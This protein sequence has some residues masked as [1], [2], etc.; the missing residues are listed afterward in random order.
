MTERRPRARDSDY[1]PQV[2][3]EDSLGQSR[4]GSDVGSCLGTPELRIDWTTVGRDRILGGR[5]TAEE[6]LWGVIITMGIA[7]SRASILETQDIEWLTLHFFCLWGVVA[8]SIHYSARFNN[9]DAFHR[10]MW[11]LFLLGLAGQISFLDHS[12]PGFAGATAFLYALVAAAFLRVAL[13]SRRRRKFCLYWAASNLG[14]CC[15]LLL[16]ALHPETM[17]PY[18]RGLLWCNAVWEAVTSPRRGP[19]RARGG[20]RSRSKHCVHTYRW[21]C[22]SSISSR[23]NTQATICCPS[24]PNLNPH[25]DPHLKPL[26]STSFSHLHP[27]PNYSGY[28]LPVAIQYVIKRYEGFHMMTIVCTFLFPLALQGAT[29]SPQP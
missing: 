26:G 3:E 12:L 13:L 11:A 24:P 8:S 1:H 25:P 2:D 5:V 15:L 6:S 23:R 18:E 16:L 4:T 17:A 27:H 10:I 9:A 14:A 22:G 21:R 29:A 28:D 19:A 20:G 7:G